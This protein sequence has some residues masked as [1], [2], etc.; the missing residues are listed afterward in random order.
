CGL[1][2]AP[3]QACTVDDDH[4]Y[5]TSN[6]TWTASLSGFTCIPS[7]S[8][9]QVPC[10][11]DVASQNPDTGVCKC[12]PG[13]T[14]TAFCSLDLNG[15]GYMNGILNPAYSLDAYN[16]CPPALQPTNWQPHV[17][18]PAGQNAY[19]D[20]AAGACGCCPAPSSVPDCKVAADAK[21]YQK[22]AAAST[23]SFV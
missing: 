4:T 19:P 23:W 16:Q 20:S 6:T 14:S 22:W 21:S 17:A 5:S 8:G 7:A 9:Q 11:G 10:G 2:P 3:V 18:C 1:C 13:P 15:H 12:C